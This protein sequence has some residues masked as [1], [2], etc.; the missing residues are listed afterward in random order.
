MAAEKNRNLAHG[1]A[2]IARQLNVRITSYIIEAVTEFKY[3]GGRFSENRGRLCLAKISFLCNNDSYKCQ[4]G[5]FWCEEV[6]SR[7]YFDNSDTCG[8]R[9]QGMGANLHMFDIRE[10]K[11]PRNM[12]ANQDSYRQEGKGDERGF[13]ESFK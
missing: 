9:T 10:K 13:F 4:D 11:T 7:N 2:L 12:S 1:R 8:T 3:L 6:V 5:V